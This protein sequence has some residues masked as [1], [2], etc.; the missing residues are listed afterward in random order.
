MENYQESLN[1]YN[2]AIKLNPEKKTLYYYKAAALFNLASLEEALEM[3]NKALELDPNYI[4]AHI[5]KGN[6]T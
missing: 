5:G 3:F 6:L 4:E 1:F 2:E